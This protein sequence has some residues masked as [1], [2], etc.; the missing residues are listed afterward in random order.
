MINNLEKWVEQRKENLLERLRHD[1]KIGVVPMF[2]NDKIDYEVSDRVSAISCGGIG[3][4][5]K[6]VKKIGFDRMIDEGLRLLKLHKPYHESDHILNMVYNIICGGQCLEDIELLRN[7]PTYLDA[8]RA[9][10]I[11][12]PT[13]AGD[14]LRRFGYDDV[15]SLMNAANRANQIVWSHNPKNKSEKDAIIDVDGMIKTTHGEKKQGLDFSYKG[16]WGF[17]PLIITEATTETHLFTVNRPG[18]KVSHDGAAPWIDESI[19]VV[20]N[21]FREVYLRGDSDF[22][23]TFKFDEWDEAGVKFDFAYDARPNL[24][25]IAENL[26]E[27]GWERRPHPERSI[28]TKVRRKKSNVKK[29]V[30]KRR[31]FLNKERKIDYVAEFDYRPGNCKKTYRMVVVK[32]ILKVTKGQLRLQDEVRYFF[33]VTNIEDMTADEVVCFNH[34][35]AN[36]E[37]KLEQLKNGVN[38]L[39]MPA[40]EFI[41]NWAYMVIGS[42]AWNIKSWIGQVMPD[43]VKGEQVTRM[44]FKRFKHCMINVPC[45]IT[46]SGRRLIFRILNYNPWIETFYS[47]FDAIKNLN[48]SSA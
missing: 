16:T 37:N 40:S 47:T 29:Q 33:Y 13:T 30:I 8:L 18:N 42:L 28:K 2:A 22:S 26:P 23:L 35:R 3:I 12:D 20:K 27:N 9:K 39:K 36:H 1:E 5:H 7:N 21:H 11:P 6:L 19:A 44:E 41:A 48:F 25:K 46:Y 32:R 43:Q 10:R 34:K 17:S 24:V 31:S 15:I 4:V 38:A 14:F 45:Q